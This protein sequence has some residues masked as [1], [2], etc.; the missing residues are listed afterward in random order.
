MR[1]K[2]IERAILCFVPKTPHGEQLLY[3]KLYDLR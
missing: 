1:M 2:G 3:S